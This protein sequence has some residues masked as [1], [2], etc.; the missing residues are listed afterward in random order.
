MR[1]RNGTYTKTKERGITRI[2]ERIK[3]RYT[4]NITTIVLRHQEPMDK[5][6]KELKI[7]TDSEDFEQKL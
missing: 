5:M 7:I 3:R 2:T 4:V 1:R 6:I